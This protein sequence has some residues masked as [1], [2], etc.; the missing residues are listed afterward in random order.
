MTTVNSNVSFRKHRKLKIILLLLL[1]LFIAPG[2]ILFTED[3]PRGIIFLAL[4][5][6]DIG[7]VIGLLT[8]RYY[9]WIIVFLILIIVAIFFKFN[10]W[11]FYPQILSFGY[12]GLGFVSLFSSIRFIKSYTQVPFLR[13][14]GFSASIVLFLIT[15][16]LWF[17]TLHW[18]FAGTL[19]TVGMVVF[20]PFLFAFI[21]TLPWS[22]YINWE[23]AEKVIFF[24]AI[25]IPMVFIFLISSIMFV[26]PDAWSTLINSPVIPWNM[27]PNEFF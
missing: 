11:P 26:F 5:F 25:I 22:N 6:T 18:V 8:K 15:I 4:I 16:G 13:Y 7:I 23:K 10:R 19:L 9:N 21:F 20:I 1:P 17:K 27:S 3:D 14:V 2:T 24:R 12:G